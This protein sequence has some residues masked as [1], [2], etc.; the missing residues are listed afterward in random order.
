MIST[1]F[2]MA[3]QHNPKGVGWTQPTPPKSAVM[4]QEGTTPLPG[5]SAASLGLTSKAASQTEHGSGGRWKSALL[6]KTTNNKQYW[7]LE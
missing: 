7:M 3:I 4:I 5:Q 6:V 1:L 2:P